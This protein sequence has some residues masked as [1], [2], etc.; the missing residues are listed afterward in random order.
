MKVGIINVTGYAGIELPVRQY[1]RAAGVAPRVD[2]RVC[3]DGP[4]G[5]HDD[6]EEQ[7]SNR[8]RRK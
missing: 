8:H 3:L 4:G 2:L 1:Q 5:R 7:Y 6:G